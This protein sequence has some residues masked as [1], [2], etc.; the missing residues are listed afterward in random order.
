MVHLH[1]Y[2]LML[3]HTS[4]SIPVVMCHG[5]NVPAQMHP[6]SIPKSRVREIL[7]LLVIMIIII[8][9]MVIIM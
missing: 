1:A 9:V 7:V 6:R 3:M 4:I 2:I 5:H 8:I